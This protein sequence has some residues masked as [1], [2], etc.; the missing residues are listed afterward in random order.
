[1]REID[2]RQGDYETIPAISMVLLM[3]LSTQLLVLA[4]WDHE[5]EKGL[6]EVPK[7]TAFQQHF[8]YSGPVQGENQNQ[9]ASSFPFQ[10]AAFQD[11]FY[12]DPAAIYGKVSDPS[13]L[14]LGPQYGF[15]LEE[16]NTDDHDNDGIDDLNDLDDDNDGINDLIERF[17]GCYGCLLYTSPSPRDRG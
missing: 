16:T 5:E 3:L 11:P 14:A 9:P 6:I 15:F 12:N 13:A 7:R 1:M 10:E 8:Q 17:D 2:E 4:N